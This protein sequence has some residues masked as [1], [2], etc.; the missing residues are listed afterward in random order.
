M[1]VYKLHP[2]KVCEGGCGC[3]WMAIISFLL[4]VVSHAAGDMHNR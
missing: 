2:M 4:S 3:G 1:Q